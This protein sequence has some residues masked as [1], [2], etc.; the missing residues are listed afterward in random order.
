MTESRPFWLFLA[1]SLGV[2]ASLLTLPFHLALNSQH[3]D[4]DDGDTI[5]A[6][7]SQLP[8]AAAVPA[9]DLEVE[10]ALQSRAEALIERPSTVSFDALIRASVRESST[11]RLRE[12]EEKY[13][14]EDLKGDAFDQRGDGQS[15]CLHSPVTYVS[16]PARL[17]HPLLMPVTQSCSNE[18][19]TYS[20]RSV[21]V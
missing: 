20:R 5:L 16:K 2:V 11:G 12:L 14:A 4:D 18:S 1:F 8:P 7:D 3:L 17:T 9:G 19:A 21:C 13:A 15:P 6:P 10:G